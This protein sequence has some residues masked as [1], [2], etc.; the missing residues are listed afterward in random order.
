[1]TSRVTEIIIDSQDPMTLAK[2]WAEVLDYQVAPP[3]K[4]G[5][6]GISA[7]A[8]GEERPSEDAYRAAAQVPTIVFVPVPESKTLKNRTHLDIWSVDRTQEEEVAWLESRGARRVDIGQRDVPWVVMADPEGNEF[9]V[10][11]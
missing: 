10:L 1:M 7:W 9:C 4:E 6:V 3:A 5:W 2:W 11:G 8:A